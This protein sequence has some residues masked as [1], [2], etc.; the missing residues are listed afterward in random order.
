MVSFPFVIEILS[1]LGSVPGCRVYE[2]LSITTQC[3]K[4]VYFGDF[5]PLTKYSFI[6]DSWES[7]W[8]YS[9]HSG[10]EFGK[11]QLTAGKFYNDPEADKGRCPIHT[12]LLCHHYES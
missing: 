4:P 6:I 11:F 8:V 12:F 1:F 2:T 3:R 9:E 7:E 5:G 10:K